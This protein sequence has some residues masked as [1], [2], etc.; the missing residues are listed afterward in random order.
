MK[1]T[2]DSCGRSTDF[3]AGPKGSVPAGWGM[4]ELEKQHLFL[5]SACG[6]AANFVGGLSPSLRQAVDRKKAMDPDTQAE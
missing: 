2:C 5:C 6:N 1:F 4:R 3:D